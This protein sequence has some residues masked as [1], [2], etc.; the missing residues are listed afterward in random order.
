MLDK[1]E[2]D[3]RWVQEIAAS[4]TVTAL[5]H[6]DQILPEIELAGLTW[7]E[8]LAGRSRNMR[9]QLGRRRR[10]LERD[11]EVVLR[12]SDEEH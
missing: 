9:S 11:H 10:R 5:S 12:L 6:R 7:T 8:Y 3:A 1:V 2:A 4:E